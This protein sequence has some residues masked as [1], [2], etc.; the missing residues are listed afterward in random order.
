MRIKKVIACMICVAFLAG[1]AAMDKT[2]DPASK[3]FDEKKE[4]D[5]RV[6]P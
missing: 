6:R 3:R 2:T 5:M 4:V 1:C